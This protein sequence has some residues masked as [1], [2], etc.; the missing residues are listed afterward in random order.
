MCLCG[1]EYPSGIHITDQSKSDTVRRTIFDY[2]TQTRNK[3]IDSLVDADNKDKEINSVASKLLLK[4]CS[5]ID[6]D[7]QHQRSNL[8]NYPILRILLNF[9]TLDFLNVIAM[10]FGETSFDAVIG[11]EKKQQL[12]DILIEIGLNSTGFNYQLVGHLLT[13]LARQIANESS[14]I[15]VEDIIFTQIIDYLCRYVIIRK[16]IYRYFITF[17][18]KIRRA[19]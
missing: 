10:S 13:F 17:C 15:N 1:Q 11:L 5:S 7:H 18:V 2:L 4:N 8:G 3:L 19:S 12:I 14:N 9:N 6:L 16:K